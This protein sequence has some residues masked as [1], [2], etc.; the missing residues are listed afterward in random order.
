MSCCPILCLCCRYM[1]IRR[2]CSFPGT[3][4]APRLK[5]HMATAHGGPKA[6]CPHCFNNCSYD[7]MAR[8]LKKCHEHNAIAEEKMMFCPYCDQRY[9][10]GNREGFEMGNYQ[11]NSACMS[12][13]TMSYSFAQLWPSQTTSG[14][15]TP[16]R[17][18]RM[19][20]KTTHINVPSAPTR[21]S[22]VPRPWSI[23]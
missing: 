22:V 3:N 12:T 10:T 23:M 19:E 8:H 6:S 11:V 14:R 7:N 1:C 18:M 5:Q 16:M 21:T 13:I 2:G 9:M 15:N 17:K 4:S 20:V